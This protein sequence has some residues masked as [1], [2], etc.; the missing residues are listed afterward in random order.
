MKQAWI[1][2]SWTDGPDEES[3]LVWRRPPLY[4]GVGGVAVFTLSFARVFRSRS[5]AERY[6]RSGWAP[7]AR[8]RWTLVPLAAAMLECEAARFEAAR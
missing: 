8:D 6:R 3:S 7:G 5:A 4:L 2:Q 1:L